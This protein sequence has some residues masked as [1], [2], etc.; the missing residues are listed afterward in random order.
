MEVYNKYAALADTIKIEDITSNE[1]NQ[2]I[3]QRLKDNDE[4][5]LNSIHITNSNPNPSYNDHY[6]IPEEEGE[7]VGWLGYYIGNNTNLKTL[8][9]CEN[10]ASHSHIRSLFI[11]LNRNKTIQNIDFDFVNSSDAL[12]FHML[13]NFFK[14]NHN[15]T[16]F[17]VSGL[18]SAEGAR[19]LS[20]TLGSCS[21]SLKRLG[22]EDLNWDNIEDVPLNNTITALSIHPQLEELDFGGTSIGRNGCLSLANTILR[23]STPKLQ[24]L[25]LRE[26]NID[27]EGLQHLVNAL[28]YIN[29][30][31]ELYMPLIFSIT[32]QGWKTLSTLLEIPA[33]SL[34]EL[35]IH[36]NNI[37]D[38]EALTFANALANNSML[39]ALDLQNCDITP[40]GWAPFSKLLC[41]T[42]SVN[43]TYL[44]NHTLYYLGN[45]FYEDDFN[46]IYGIEHHLVLNE[47]IEGRT[48]DIAMIKRKI[49]MKKIVHVHSH[50]D[51]QPFFEWEFKVLPT[52][53][54][55]FTKAAACTTAE[56]DEK[57]KKMKLSV[58]YD[59]IK[60]FP[61]LYIES[62]TRKEIAGYT[63]M[64][65]ELLQGGQIDAEQQVKLEE[66]RRCKARA[67]RRL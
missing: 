28:T 46:D 41:D 29:T 47:A 8:H 26:S 11:G 59:F 38:E 33:G 9:L 21:R 61:M 5:D 49:A 64:E 58:V 10:W 27:D 34:E 17:K 3:L 6:Y 60:E 25:R 40:E 20:L 22:L 16:E 24:K 54:R 23:W 66:I 30:L 15:L 50:F 36:G 31:Q 48:R 44:S 18:L 2:S 35:L 14:N 53:I 19:Q 62:V 67:M 65:E 4:R 45:H 51:M 42:S 1:Q 7:D 39:M 63:T 52:M 55:W 13:D 37:G 57:I 43:N 12:L 56:Y 32:N